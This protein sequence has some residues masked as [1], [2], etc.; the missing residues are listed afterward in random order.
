[1][2]ALGKP[3]LDGDFDTNGQIVAQSPTERV[4][5]RSVI[6]TRTL[7]PP[8]V[9]TRPK[10]VAAKIEP[11][12]DRHNSQPPLPYPLAPR[13]KPSDIEMDRSRDYLLTPF[14]KATLIDRYLMPGES[15]QDM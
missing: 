4:L 2:S 15:F 12:H 3:V 7:L 13:P 11:N 9:E 5:E 10:A 6:V 8:K 14:G 1:M